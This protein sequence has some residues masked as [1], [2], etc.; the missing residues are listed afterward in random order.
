VGRRTLIQL[1]L[2]LIGVIVWALGQRND[3]SRITLAGVAFFAA[4]FLLR[5][6]KKT[7]TAE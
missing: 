4:A 2:V 7:D 6:V 1:S 5:F 3:D